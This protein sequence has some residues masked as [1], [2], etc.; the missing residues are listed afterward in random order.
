MRRLLRA[1]RQRSHLIRYHRKPAPGITSPRRLNGSV[2]RQ[3]IGLLGNRANH[4]QHLADTMNLLRQIFH[5]RGIG[6]DIVGQEFD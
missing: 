3:Q 1:M 2:Q 5:L 6:R 4:I